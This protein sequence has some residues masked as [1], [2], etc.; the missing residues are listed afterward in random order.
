MFANR[1]VLLSVFLLGMSGGMLMA[2]P[3]APFADVPAVQTVINERCVICHSVDR[4]TQAIA[5][6]ADMAAIERKMIGMGAV[7]S[8]NERSVLGTFWGT[9]LRDVNA[10]PPADLSEYRA[11]L[12][13]RCT[14]CHDLTLVEQ[15][16]RKN[17]PFATVADQMAQRGV[18]LSGHEQSVLGTFWGSPLK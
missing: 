4:I 12:S 8:Q 5:R 11:I 2:A 17:L 14:S 15:A 7:L 3:T 9:P 10:Q 16:V 6:G 1:A 18:V 13:A